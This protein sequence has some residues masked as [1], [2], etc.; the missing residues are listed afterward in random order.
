MYTITKQT[1]KKELLTN[2][3]KFVINKEQIFTNRKERLQTK[4]PTAKSY[5]KCPRQNLTAKATAKS[6]GK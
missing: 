4:T 2:K 1:C 5:G 3:N 6:H